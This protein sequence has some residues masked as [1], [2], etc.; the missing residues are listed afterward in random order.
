MEMSEEFSRVA[1]PELLRE[2]SNP[3]RF[4]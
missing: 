3:F 4:V 1:S 2:S